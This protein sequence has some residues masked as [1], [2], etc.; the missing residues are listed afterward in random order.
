MTRQIE[1]QIW[2]YFALLPPKSAMLDPFMKQNTQYN[3]IHKLFSDKTILD[4]AMTL[5]K[6]CLLYIYI[7]ISLWGLIL[8]LYALKSTVLQM[9]SQGNFNKS[10][11]KVRE[12]SGNFIFW[13]L[14]QPCT[15]C[16]MLCRL[17][18][19]NKLSTV[20]IKHQ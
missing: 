19:K 8:N 11:G 20:W 6:Q 5:I 18:A 9:K 2:S 13:C 15:C 1:T 10:Q 17:T 4:T 12:K 7:K 16:L 3:I 14:W